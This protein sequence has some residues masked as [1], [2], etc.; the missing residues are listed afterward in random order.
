MRKTLLE[1]LQERFFND[2]QDIT[3]SLLAKEKSALIDEAYKIAH[4]N[5]IVDIVDCFD[6][7]YPPFY[8][9][10]I[11]K[12]LKTKENLILKIFRKWMNYRHHERYNFFVY[13]DLIDIMRDTL[14]IE[15]GE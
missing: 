10:E 7:E 11:K 15:E 5:E 9:D 2:Y 8:K 4:Y 6:E 13:E 3:K 12:I 1:K 14:L